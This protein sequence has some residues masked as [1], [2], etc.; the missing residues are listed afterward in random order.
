MIISRRHTAKEKVNMI[1]EG[2]GA[3]TESMEVA[4]LMKREI[5]KRDLNVHVDQTSLGSWFIPEQE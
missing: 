4:R 2:Q 5:R 1:E 3:F